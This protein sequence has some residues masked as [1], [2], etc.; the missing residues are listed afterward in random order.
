MKII[1]PASLKRLV[2]N[3][4][5]ALKVPS[6]QCHIIADVLVEAN[7]RGV[8]SHGVNRL[9]EYM[10]LILDGGW[11]LNVNPSVERL[12]GNTALMDGN[13]GLG[14]VTA[15]KAMDLAINLAEQ[16]HVGVVS[17]KR[18]GHFGM[19]AYYS[20]MALEKDMIGIVMTNASPGISPWG[21][22][23][24]ILGN[25]PW[26]VAVPV[27][28]G[29]PIVLD[30]ANSI[31]ARGKIRN[32]AK[33]NERIPNNWALDDDGQ[34]TEDPSA[35]LKG[36][37]L[38]IGGYKGYGLTLMIDILT[39]VLSG[40]A[41]GPRVGSPRDSENPQNVG[42]LFFALNVSAFQPIDQFKRTV[43]E[44]ITEIKNSP[45][46]I[47][48]K[49]IFVPGEIENVKKLKQLEEGIVLTEQE[50]NTINNVG[51]HLN[52]GCLI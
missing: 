9:E 49:E 47:G 25:N 5:E 22:T 1:N 37:L 12:T 4:L 45:K 35:A 28:E 18:G 51:I 2:V 7:L 13:D 42:Q 48:T 31:V 8:P 20:M 3:I 34:P 6:E 26:S 29:T 24:P 38:P 27:S 11:K 50:V 39:G 10:N 52:L 17:V 14:I 19:A 46:A 33:Q 32:S 40:A 21:G 44:Y 23:K 36:S 43:H 41:Y 16:N 30:M 15:H